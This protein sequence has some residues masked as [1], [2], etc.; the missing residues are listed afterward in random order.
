MSTFSKDLYQD[1]KPIINTDKDTLPSSHTDDSI[2]SSKPHTLPTP[3]ESNS[4]SPTQ[5][6]TPP[7]FKMSRPIA[8]NQNPVGVTLPPSMPLR[9][10]KGS[11]KTFKGDY[12]E[13]RR[14][15]NHV[16]KL[17]SKHQVILD[18]DKCDAVL[19]YCSLGVEDF[20]QQC[21][22]FI[23]PNWGL[24]RDELLRFYDAERLTSKYEYADLQ[25]F[26]LRHHKRKCQSLSKW[27]EYYRRYTTIAGQL[28]EQGVLS[29]RDYRAY[30]WK[31]LPKS[32]QKRLE[33][34][35]H[36]LDPTWD[37]SQPYNVADI[38]TVAESHFLRNKFTDTTLTAYDLKHLSDFDGDDTDSESS[39]DSDES[40][41]EEEYCQKKKPK[42]LRKSKKSRKDLL[43]SSEEE[44]DSDCRSK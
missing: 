6:A 36:S 35:L 3:Q 37:M 30:F 43:S 25:R 24:L 39:S 10:Q 13:V 4:N 22:N 11:P 29:D 9:G 15:I 18:Q 23:Q 42:Y 33:M 5:Q 14:F 26:I 17:F 2:L 20:I 32:L 31:G 1:T 19:E 38:L 41:S 34:K 7:H 8:L 40:S 28:K 16:E 44:E 27:K 21:Q 12:R